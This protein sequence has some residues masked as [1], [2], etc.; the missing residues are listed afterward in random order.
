MAVGDTLETDIKGADHFGVATTL[1]VGGVAAP[2]LAF[3]KGDANAQD[4]PEPLFGGRHY[5]HLRSPTVYLVKN[6]KALDCH[7][8]SEF[9][10]VLGK[11]RDPSITCLQKNM[12]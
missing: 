5:P 10:H 12:A 1:V 9:K 8:T 2:N 6:R 4:T 11:D 7:R 3:Q